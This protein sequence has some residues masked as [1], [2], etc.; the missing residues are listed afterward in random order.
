MFKFNSAKFLLLL[1]LACQA[2]SPT[3]ETKNAIT[4]SKEARQLSSLFF[5]IIGREPNPSDKKINNIASI[6]LLD[7][8]YE[9]QVDALLNSQQFIDQGFFHFHEQ[10]MLLLHRQDM[11]TIDKIFPED[12]HA[13]QLELKELAKNSQ[14]YWDILRYRH[15]Y[16]ALGSLGGLTDLVCDS[17]NGNCNINIGQVKQGIINIINNIKTDERDNRNYP[18]RDRCCTES[19]GHYTEKQP[20]KQHEGFCKTAKLLVHSV[21]GTKFCSLSSDASDASD[22]L[23]SNTQEN[24]GNME[25]ANN[26]KWGKLHVAVNVYLSLYLGVRTDDWLSVHIDRQDVENLS[27]DQELPIVEF[28][29][30]HYLRVKFPE[31][32]QGIH[33]S[34]FWLWT[35]RTS[36]ANQ[37]LHRARVIY[38]SWFCQ[39][40]SP[41]QATEAGEKPDEKEIEA[42]N[43]YFADNDQHAKGDNNCFSCHQEVQPLANYFGKL[44]GASS[45]ENDVLYGLGAKFLA[46]PEDSFDRPAGYWEGGKFHGEFRGLAGLAKSLPKIGKVSECLVNSAWNIMLGSDLPQ[47]TT[48][49]VSDAINKFKDTKNY[50]QLLKHLLLTDKAKTYF[51]ENR[52]AMVTKFSDESP[53]TE[54]VDYVSDVK[55]IIESYCTTCHNTEKE[56]PEILEENNTFLTDKLQT[57]YQ[58][59]FIQNNMPPTYAYRNVVPIELESSEKTSLKCY[60]DQEMEKAGQ[61]SPVESKHLDQPHEIS[62]AQQ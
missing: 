59:V 34:P 14:D 19:Q 15:R 35:Y 3:A 49:E 25:T 18:Y 37:H 1:I 27:D 8:T 56:A 9:E 48:E 12:K 23:P 38:N 6:E 10:R 41:D 4:D 42:F 57:I 61:K 50:R 62:G 28:N 54:E 39:K 40:I 21:F 58:R 13:L 44:A 43:D 47:L 7:R 31:D 11:A 26:S 32:L 55:P 60:L 53:C 30:N 29:R 52:A 36:V 20:E 17:S 51:T 5:A 46:R 24:L 16:L 33:A 45:V 22:D 2:R